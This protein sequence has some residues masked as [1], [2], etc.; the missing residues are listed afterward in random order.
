MIVITHENVHTVDW[1]KWMAEFE[2]RYRAYCKE[3][4][5]EIIEQ[6]AEKK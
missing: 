6:S 3:N 1:K 4:D 2:R 5:I